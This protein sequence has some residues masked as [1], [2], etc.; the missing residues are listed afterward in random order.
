VWYRWAASF[1]GTG[2]AV[3]R[4]TQALARMATRSRYPIQPWIIGGL[5]ILSATYS[6]IASYV[7]SR[8]AAV[9]DSTR[10]LW[11]VVFSILVTVWSRNDNRYVVPRATRDYSYLLMFFFWPMVLLYHL[12]RSRGTEGLMMYVGF[13][14]TYTAPYVIQVLTWVVNTHAS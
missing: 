5:V 2:S 4:S 3:G 9:S 14:A 6:I 1:R 13:L 11:I 12:V 7:V 8:G 10:V